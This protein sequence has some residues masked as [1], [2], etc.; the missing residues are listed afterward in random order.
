[1]GYTKNTCKLYLSRS[2]IKHIKYIA[3]HIHVRTEIYLKVVVESCGDLADK[4]TSTTRQICAV[5]TIK[6]YYISNIHV[7]TLD[8]GTFLTMSLA[9]PY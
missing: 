6:S 4:P 1:M 2:G 7:C 9:D 3:V 5:C 8:R